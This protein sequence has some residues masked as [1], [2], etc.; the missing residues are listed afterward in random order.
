M[1]AEA[2]LVV[3]CVGSALAVMIGALFLGAQHRDG[4]QR[5]AYWAE[6][7]ERV[8]AGRLLIAEDDHGEWCVPIPHTPGYFRRWSPWRPA[9]WVRL[10]VSRLRRRIVWVETQ[11]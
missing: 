9:D 4:D 1:T 7:A 2:I 3:F 11:P 5:R 8:Y 6:A 10:G